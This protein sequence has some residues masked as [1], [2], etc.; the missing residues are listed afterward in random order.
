[1][2]EK[3]GIQLGLEK[4]EQITAKRA[5]ELCKADLM[6]NMVVEITSLQGFI[7][8]QYALVTVNQRSWLRRSLSIICRVP[9][10][11]CSRNKNQA[12]LWG[13]LTAWIV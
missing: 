12:W 13:L 3:V 11:I 1:M 8:Q 4:D 10:V 9:L 2:V 7:G 5:A 6:T